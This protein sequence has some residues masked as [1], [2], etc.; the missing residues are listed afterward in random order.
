MQPINRVCFEIQKEKEA[1]N[2]TF[3][4]VVYR[5]LDWLKRRSFV[6]DPMAVL[7][8]DQ[9]MAQ[10]PAGDGALV[11]SLMLEEEGKR[12]WGIRY[13]HPDSDKPELRWVGEVTLLDEGGGRIFYQNTIGVLHTG[14]SVAPYEL[15]C[16]NPTLNREVLNEFKCFTKHGHRLTATLLGLAKSEHSVDLLVRI[17]NDEKRSHPV[18]Y[19]TPSDKGELMADVPKMARVLAGM[20]HVVVAEDPS[21]GDKVSSAMPPELSCPPGGIRIYWPDYHT[22]QEPRHHRVFTDWQLLKMGDKCP[23][24]FVEIISRQAVLRDPEG[25]A[26]WATLQ[27]W[28]HRQAVRSNQSTQQAL[29]MLAMFEEENRKQQ[30]ALATANKEIA[31]LTEILSKAREQAERFSALLK[32]P[33]SQDADVIPE[34]PEDIVVETKGFEE[35]EAAEGE[36]PITREETETEDDDAESEEATDQNAGWGGL[37]TYDSTYASYCAR[38]LYEENRAYKKGTSSNPP[39]KSKIPKKDYFK[40]H[41]NVSM[42]TGD[43]FEDSNYGYG[44]VL[45]INSV[46]IYG[47]HSDGHKVWLYGTGKGTGNIVN[48]YPLKKQGIKRLLESQ[49]PEE[50]R[51]LFSR[52]EESEME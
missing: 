20:A 34:M 38:I 5:V 3:D 29:E 10:T 19:V 1:E 48:P 50:V 43:W 30:Q 52:Y 6:T 22:N 40:I 17:L 24:R 8:C 46:E 11:E 15:Y 44:R 26:D 39:P 12:G 13:S 51:V 33:D 41:E 9:T 14:D 2:P 21:L 4:A 16:S 42:R 49:V 7:D 35:E 36:E 27:N 28:H 47:D 25:Y 37:S 31:R 23:F 18:V 45:Q 32:D